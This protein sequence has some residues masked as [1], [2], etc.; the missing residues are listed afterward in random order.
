MRRDLNMRWDGI[1]RDSGTGSTDKWFSWLDTAP[2]GCTRQT[3][4]RTRTSGERNGRWPLSRRAA[5]LQERVRH[6][7]FRNRARCV[8]SIV[9]RHVVCPFASSA[10][11][12]GES[13]P[14]VREATRR[15]A[16]GADGIFFI[17]P[18]RFA[19]ISKRI[20]LLF[21]SR[22]SPRAMI[23]PRKERAFARATRPRQ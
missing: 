21:D 9:R 8:Q 1:S 20:R 10:V 23:S 18:R 3:G 12:K 17:H 15:S 11:V 7:L 4:G 19:G 6:C 16:D 5:P 22:K 2:D 14:L 13:G